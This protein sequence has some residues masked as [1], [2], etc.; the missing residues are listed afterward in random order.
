MQNF[1]K[2]LIGTLVIAA[3]SFG[4]S[5]ADVDNSWYLGAGLG[6]NNYQ[7]VDATSHLQDDSDLA[8]NALVGYQLNKYFAIE[9]G[10][11]DLGTDDDT[12]LWGGNTDGSE[13]IDVD[14]FTLGLVGTLPLDD[15]WF[16]TGEIGAYQYHLAHEMGQGKYVSATDTAAYFGIGLGYNITDALAISAKYRRFSDVNETAWNTVDMD[17][18]TIGLQL[19]YRFGIESEPTPLAITETKPVVEPKVEP[20]I[21]PKYQTKIEKEEVTIL[22]GFDSS[23]LSSSGKRQLDKIVRE[24]KNSIDDSIVLIGQADNQG[25]A[26]YNM[27]LSKQRVEA[28]ANYLLDSGLQVADMSKQ[29]IGEKESRA[30]STQSRS[31]ERVVVV[32]LTST[33]KILISSL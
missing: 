31:L 8:W 12:H 7:S 26:D 19:T 24:S 17:A 11:Q 20:K 4:A 27:K 23:E 2:T 5:A 30:N 21:E 15:K 18:Q 25:A 29:A 1:N 14:G 3:F 10:W 16:A 6:Q 9:A 13:A 22:F 32:E 33:K 28:V